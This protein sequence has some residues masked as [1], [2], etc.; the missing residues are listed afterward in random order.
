MRA[1]DAVAAGQIVARLDTCLFQAERARLQASRDAT[2]AQ[3]GLAR[4]TNERQ[5]ALN[6]R[7]FAPGQTVDDTSLRLVQVQAGVAEIDASLTAVDIA[8]DK[9]A[10]PAPYAGTVAARSLDVGS[11]AAPGIPVISL[12]E[13]APPRFR[14]G[15]AP[16]LAIILSVG[17]M[18]TVEV[19]GQ[20][21]ALRLASLSPE[22]DPVTRSRMA[23]FEA[24]NA[25]L[26]PGRT[27]G[28]LILT[29]RI[30]VPDAWVPLSA[31]RPGPQA[32][33]VLTT[34]QNGTVGL[35]AAE[36]VLLDGER[37]FVRGTFQDAMPY[38]PNG[39][40]RVVPGQTVTVPGDV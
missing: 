36:I 3:V 27:M 13:A 5:T 18:A 30:D 20:T 1:G 19:K 7:R 32:T 21:H 39:T 25:L 17:D 38:L 22:L 35:E 31:L 10:P 15:L 6:D 8:L 29:Q 37:A 24:D 12:T 16:E 23:W 40:H 14:V 9:A 34:A 26:P 2:L 33:W 11:L 4:R 28:T